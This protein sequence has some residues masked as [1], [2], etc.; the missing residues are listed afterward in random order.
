[1]CCGL[2]V[3]KQRDWL[4][5]LRQDD[6]LTG[7][8]DVCCWLCAGGPTGEGQ[9]ERGKHT[10]TG[11]QH[12][13]YAH[14]IHIKSLPPAPFNPVALP[15]WGFFF[16]GIQDT[17]FTEVCEK[18]YSDWSLYNLHHQLGIERKL[19]CTSCNIWWYN[20]YSVVIITVCYHRVN[21]G[22]YYVIKWV[23]V[24]FTILWIL[25]ISGFGCT[26]QK[27]KLSFWLDYT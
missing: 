17:T 18:V 4:S 13:K 20:A 11:V 8:Q 5:C 25:S 2:I 12:L 16:I 21:N 14:S 3:T 27:V 24:V 1:M 9:G 23:L 19:D 22:H 7:W 6:R 10:H 26:H 15:S